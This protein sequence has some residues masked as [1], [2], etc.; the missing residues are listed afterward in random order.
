L[1]ECLLEVGINISDKYPKQLTSEM[2]EGVDKVIVMA[3]PHTWPEYLKKSP[4]LEYWKI[5]DPAGRSLDFYRQTRDEIKSKIINS[6][7]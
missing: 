5:S 4:K 1:L 7:S 6:K 2:I 3:E